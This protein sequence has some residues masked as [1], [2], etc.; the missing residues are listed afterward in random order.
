M[1][2]PLLLQAAVPA[3][4][5]PATPWATRE[6]VDQATG[7]KSTTA[8]VLAR[9]GRARLSLRCDAQVPVVSVQYIPGTALGAS[10]DRPVS[11]SFDG[12]APLTFDWEFPGNAAFVRD[13]PQVTALTVAM[14]SA[15]TIKVH[16]LSLT[17]ADVDATFDG[18]PSAGAVS[19]VLTACGYTLGQVPLEKEPAAA[20]PK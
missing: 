11:M 1:I 4:A 9:D 7:A 17:N 14:A 3:A 19:A 15:K 12:A 5:A 18:P 8:S 13:T 20:A 2:L 6:R 10:D 16:A